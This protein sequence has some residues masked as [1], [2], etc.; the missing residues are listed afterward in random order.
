VI[1][2]EI[3][4]LVNCVCDMWESSLEEYSL[5]NIENIDIKQIRKMIIGSMKIAFEIQGMKNV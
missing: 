3:E 4:S 2:D 5:Y 1:Q